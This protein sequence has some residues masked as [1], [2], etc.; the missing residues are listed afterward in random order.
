MRLF[1]AKLIRDI[2]AAS[3]VEYGLICA[4]IVLAM[5]AGLNAVAGRTSTMWSDV[6]DNV[7]RAVG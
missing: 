4:L 1:F 5:I 7:T 6:S 3:A 2:K